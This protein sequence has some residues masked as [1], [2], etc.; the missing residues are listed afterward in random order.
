MNKITCL[1]L[2]SLLRCIPSEVVNFNFHQMTNSQS[3][4]AYS[5]HVHIPEDFTIIIILHENTYVTRLATHYAEESDT[6]I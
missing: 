5:T 3:H 1:F 2:N 6:A 4:D